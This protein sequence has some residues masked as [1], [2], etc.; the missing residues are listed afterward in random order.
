MSSRTLSKKLKNL[1][2]SD[3]IKKYGTVEFG[4]IVDY[5]ELTKKPSQQ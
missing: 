2:E 4:K 5:Y 1:M 3:K